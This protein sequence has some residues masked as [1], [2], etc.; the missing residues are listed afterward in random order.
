MIECPSLGKEV[1]H[2]VNG[3]V[4]IIM[5]VAG[6]FLEESLDFFI[7]LSLDITVENI[8]GFVVF[9]VKGWMYGNLPINPCR[10]QIVVD[11]VLHSF[12]GPFTQ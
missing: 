8:I 1:S 10:L 6:I 11:W 12:H 5:I 2:E 3:N 4:L 7:F 9:Q